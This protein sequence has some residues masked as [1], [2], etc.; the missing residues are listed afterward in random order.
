MIDDEGPGLAFARCPRCGQWRARVRRAFGKLTTR[1]HGTCGI[2]PLPPGV[3][4]RQPAANP[5]SS[6]TGT[7]RR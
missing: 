7:D 3:E 2:V 6:Q 5:P 4:I 1:R